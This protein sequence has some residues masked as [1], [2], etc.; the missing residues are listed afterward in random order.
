MNLATKGGAAS[1]ESIQA[2]IT[3]TCYEL[4]TAEMKVRALISPFD[5]HFTS[6]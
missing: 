5:K 2:T 4:K 3:P 1:D 6:V